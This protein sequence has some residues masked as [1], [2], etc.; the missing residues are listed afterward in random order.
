MIR[1]HH[2]NA[3]RSMRILWLL[4][5][6]GLEYEIVNYRRDPDTNLAPPELREIN[7]LGKSPAIEDD[8]R[9]I[10]E[11]GAIVD[12][13]VRR[14]GG[15]ELAPDSESPEYDD[16]VRWLHY[17][18]GSAML[19]VMLTLY[20]SR[21]GE[22]GEPLHP[23]LESEVRNHFGYI[24]RTLEGREYLVGDSLTGAD[25]QMVFV[26]EAASKMGLINDF[27]NLEEYVERVQSRPSFRR[28]SERDG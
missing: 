17:A 19:P 12:Y 1:V 6:L 14:K 3:S 4:E 16:Y 15:G 11:S 10:F 20:V 26:I 2:L 13:L 25:V 22:A 28:A 27:E 21:L 9:I 7:P 18:E 23:R 24:S 5:E 8:G